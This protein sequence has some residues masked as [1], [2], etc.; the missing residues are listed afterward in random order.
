VS[1]SGRLLVLGTSGPRLSREEVA[2]LRRVE[3]GGA[4]L[5][6]R[7]V[8]SIDQVVEWSAAVRR[9][10]PGALL[11]VDA[12]G[13]RV[14]RLRSLFGSAPAAARLA[15]RPPA[16]SRRAGFWVGAAL[17]RVGLDVDLAPV[18]DLD[19]GATDNA[20]DGR[21]FGVE[22]RRI[23]S[24]ARAFLDGLQAAGALGCIK[25]FPGLG[26]AT[27]DTHHAVAEVALDRAALER[28]AAPF[29]KLWS[30]TRANTPA[31][32]VLV[33]HAIYPALDASRLP[34]S[35]SAAVMTDRLRRQMGFRG[36]TFS[37]DLEMNA[38][39][40]WGDLSDRCEAALAAGCDGLLVCSR[41]Q[42]APAITQRLRSKALA[43][44]RAEALARFEGFRRAATRL[45]KQVA[46]RRPAP[47]VEAIRKGLE[48]L[49]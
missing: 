13:G 11:F 15:A 2:V 3:P 37:D 18:V 12:E 46:R 20:L 5:F 10:S 39:A 31:S 41:W 49:A 36:V 1:A 38:L 43:A 29:A 48:R 14:D 9:A 34:A 21:Y 17:R 23:A 8:E 16:V 22:P 4:I 27:R 6:A 42:E 26:A 25:H 30:G 24:R 44:R 35:L 19:H 40:P 7:N 32:A 28:E 47:D 45:Q 33:S